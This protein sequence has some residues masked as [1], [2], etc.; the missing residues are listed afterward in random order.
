M[1]GF[2]GPDLK[3]THIMVAHVALGRSQSMATPNNRAEYLCAWEEGR[4]HSCG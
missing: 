2:Y 1:G 4:G 3:V